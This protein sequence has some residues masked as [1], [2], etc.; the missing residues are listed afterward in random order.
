[1]L[2][3]PM[4]ARALTIS[5]LIVL[6]GAC[7][8]ADDPAPSTPPE[9]P[10]QTAASRPVAPALPPPA[11]DD[12][13]RRARFHGFVAPKPPQ[14]K[15]TPTEKTKRVANWIVPGVMLG[16]RATDQA[17]L[18]VSTAGDETVDEAIARLQGSFGATPGSANP[19]GEL[20]VQGCPVTLVEVAG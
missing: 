14:W 9:T 18:V 5:I 1:M 16:A 3:R 2:F 17:R 19:S 11:A 10:T 20:L 13:P 6:L 7:R 15:R 4:L 12:D 8:R